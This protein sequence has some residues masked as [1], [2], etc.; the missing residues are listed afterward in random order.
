[1]MYLAGGS[2]LKQIIADSDDLMPPEGLPVA[3][4]RAGGKSIHTGLK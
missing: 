2:G 1:M 4:E 3:R